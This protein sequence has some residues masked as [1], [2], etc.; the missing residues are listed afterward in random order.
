MYNYGVQCVRTTY[1]DLGTLVRCMYVVYV[2]A[3]V[4]IWFLGIYMCILEK[5]HLVFEC[6][7][8]ITY[9]NKKKNMMLILNE[10]YNMRV[11]FRHTI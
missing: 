7:Y 4:L 11:P 2:W 1:K 8:V 9:Q 10:I 5:T 3:S 6:F